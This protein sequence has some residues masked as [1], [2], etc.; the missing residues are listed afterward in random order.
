MTALF[1]ADH[2]KYSIISNSTKAEKLLNSKDEK[3]KT[4]FNENKKEILNLI[5]KLT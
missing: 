2:N 3:F 1:K 5:S 4:L